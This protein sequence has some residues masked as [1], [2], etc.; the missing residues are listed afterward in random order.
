[1]KSPQ[2]SEV[3]INDMFTCPPDKQGDQ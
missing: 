1:M 2:M 3:E